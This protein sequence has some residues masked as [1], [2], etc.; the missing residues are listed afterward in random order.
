M[1]KNVD[2]VHHIEGVGSN[3]KQALNNLAKA[4]K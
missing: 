2:G 4:M 1:I 3:M